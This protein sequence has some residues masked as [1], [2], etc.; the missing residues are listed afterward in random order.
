VGLPQRF[1]EIGEHLF[2]RADLR[3]CGKGRGEHE[4]QGEGAKT[5][6]QF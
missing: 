6:A 4:G 1:S 2:G 5:H 3:L